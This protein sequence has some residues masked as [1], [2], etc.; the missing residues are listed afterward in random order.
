MLLD[1]CPEMLVSCMQG[2]YKYKDITTYFTRMLKGVKGVKGV[3]N[4]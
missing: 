4:L 1:S 2:K 3:K